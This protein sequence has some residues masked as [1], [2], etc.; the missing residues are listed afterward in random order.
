MTSKLTKVFGAPSLGIAVLLS[1]F[2]IPC[3]FGAAL[4]KA[5]VPFAFQ[6]GSKTLPAGEYEFQIDRQGDRVTVLGSTKV[7]GSIALE[8]IITSLAPTAHS[9]ST[10]AHIVFDKVGNTY[11]LSELWQPGEDGILVHTTKGK[12]E[13]H[14]LHLKP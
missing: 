3:A 6:V 2:T 9:D 5:D 1:M 13:H 4:M 11:T 12:H 7:K 8:S 10:H 14:V